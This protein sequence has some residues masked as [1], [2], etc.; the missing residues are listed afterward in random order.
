MR[1]FGRSGKI[2]LSIF[3]SI[4]CTAQLISL[5]PWLGR[6]AGEVW[7]G[8]WSKIVA[9]IGRVI[10]GFAEPVYHRPSAS[11]DTLFDWIQIG[12]I[13]VLSIVGGMLW[14]TLD[15]ARKTDR[16][17]LGGLRVVVRYALGATLIYYGASKVFHLQMPAPDTI[18]LLTPYGESSPMGLLWTFMGFSPAYSF[19]TGAIEVVAGFLLFFR[20]TTLLGSV[21]SAAIMT[22]VVLLNFCYDV[23]VKL[24]S[25]Q[26]L[27]MSLYLAG[28]DFHR[29]LSVF[30]SDQVK[31]RAL[32]VRNWQSRSHPLA[33]V[34]GKV[35]VIGLLLHSSVALYP[36][37]RNRQLPP[38]ER[39]LSGLYQVESFSIN[40][41]DRPPLLTDMLRWRRVYFGQKGVVAFYSMEDRPRFGRVDELKNGDVVITTF[42]PTQ[43]HT[44]KYALG[45]ED[46]TTLHGQFDGAEVSAV[47]KKIDDT[48][49]PLLSRGFHWINQSPYNR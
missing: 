29:L 49:F 35:V 21:I 34:V 46:G 40:G 25:S 18:R 4:I 32:L 19:F 17:E 28:P 23:P 41:V 36:V 33:A 14:A 22:Q 26:L 43:T 9:W 12:T 20:R 3:L 10:L 8:A 5:L 6:V 1:W 31:P 24:W 47:L 45:V 2:A 48:N 37:W 13:A 44:F 16:G 30:F 11:G 38:T 42:G 27:L 7:F 15:L 39:D